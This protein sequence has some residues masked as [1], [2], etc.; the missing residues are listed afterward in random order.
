MEI[1]TRAHRSPQHGPALVALTWIVLA[2]GCGGEPRPAADG[3]AA[4]RD[5]ASAPVVPGPSATPMRSPDRYRVAV[6]TS[7]GTFT[8]DVTRSLAPLGADRF[9][10]LVSI[11][12]FT[13]V[14]FFRMV[15][16][17]IAQFGIHGDP[18]VN[19]AWKRA[20]MPDEPMRTGNTRGT[21]TFA[22]A[23]PDTRTVQLFISTGDN[24]RKLDHQRVFAPIGTVVE[25][26]D[27]VDALNSEY[28][29]EPNF[30]RIF[31]QGNEYLRKWFPALDYIK[32]ATVVPAA[33][34]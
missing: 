2:V 6:E 19:D 10:E 17:F 32:K 1:T 15:P 7:K 24:R 20:M 5:T 34:P 29:E 13:D 30:S 27:V 11:G 18:A 4:T 14:R 3:A 31:S 26:M 12:Y 33:T 25:G 9:F 28:G 22:S 16:G 8:I 23:G 21:V